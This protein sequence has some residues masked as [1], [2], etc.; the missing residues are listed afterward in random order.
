[1]GIGASAGTNVDAGVG[2]G[3]YD[4]MAAV[5]VPFADDTH[6]PVPIGDVQEPGPAM[7]AETDMPALTAETVISSWTCSFCTAS[8]DISQPSRCWCCQQPRDRQ[9]S[10]AS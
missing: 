9:K 8:N 3:G 2:I 6:S 10:A 4:Q 7:M 1:M 5:E